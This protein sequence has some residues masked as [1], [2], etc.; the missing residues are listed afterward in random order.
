[1]HYKSNFKKVATLYIIMWLDLQKLTKMSQELKSKL[2]QN[3]NDT[4]MH[5]SEVLT[6]WL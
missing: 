2:C 3:V 1:M 6:T 4:L 5:C